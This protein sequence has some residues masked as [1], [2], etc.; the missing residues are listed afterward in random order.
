MKKYKKKTKKKDT[1]KTNKSKLTV[2][3]IWKQKNKTKSKSKSTAKST[4]RELPFILE[5]AKALPK[6]IDSSQRDTTSSVEVI[7]QEKTRRL[8]QHALRIL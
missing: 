5:K 8:L 3:L 6:K 1:T 2:N 7:A 4:V